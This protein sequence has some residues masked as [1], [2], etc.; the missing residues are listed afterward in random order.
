MLVHNMIIYSP[1]VLWTMFMF[2]L[3][4][5]V[6]WKIFYK[7]EK[8]EDYMKLNLVILLFMIMLVLIS[9]IEIKISMY[10]YE[11]IWIEK[12][13]WWLLDNNMN[14]YVFM[15]MF[16]KVIYM[17]LMFIWPAYI[18]CYYTGNK[19]KLIRKEFWKEIKD[20]KW[21]YDVMIFW[22]ILIISIILWSMYLN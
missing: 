6:I 20:V 16:A 14:L 18:I 22:V 21:K 17:L 11:E 12:I 3:V 10:I 1:I 19:E 5:W 7:E 8:K 2:L 9:L 4:K 15:W 13:K